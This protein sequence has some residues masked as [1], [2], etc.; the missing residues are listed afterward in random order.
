MGD[1]NE[2]IS[3][4][5]PYEGGLVW[6]IALYSLFFLNVILLLMEGSSFGTNIGIVVLICL[7][8]DK[9]FAFGYMFNPSNMNPRLC[10]SEVFF[11]T[12]LARVVMFAGPFAIAGAT[13]N[14]KTRMV[15]IVAGIGGMVYMFGRWFSEQRHSTV[16][17]VTCMVDAHVMM[18][19]AGMLLVLARIALRDRFRLGTVDRHIPVTVAGEFAPDEIEI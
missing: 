17:G 15:A 8:I 1:L 13:K 19:T 14:G 12:Y 6:S 9:T 16:S 11:G 2:I 18:Q 5:G 10:H 4:L 3:A 7:F